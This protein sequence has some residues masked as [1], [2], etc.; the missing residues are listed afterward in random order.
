MTSPS[1]TQRFLP[2]QRTAP[3]HKLSAARVLGNLKGVITH[4]GV[5]FSRALTHARVCCGNRHNV[6]ISSTLALYFLPGRR[7]KS[8]RCRASLRRDGPKKCLSSCVTN[9]RMKIIAGAFQPGTAVSGA[10][11]RAARFKVGSARI[12]HSNHTHR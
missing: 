1:I 4:A 6:F 3:Q 8:E 12:C 11:A 10:G 7:I 2:A 9:D 5:Y